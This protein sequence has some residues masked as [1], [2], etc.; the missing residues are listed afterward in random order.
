MK[1]TSFHIQGP[2]HIELKSFADDRG[3]FVERY[4]K[5]PFKEL[6]IPDLIQDNFSR[7]KPG[8]LRGLHYQWDQPQG[9]LVTATKGK[10]FDVAVDIRKDSPT[11]GQSISVILDGD[12]PSWFWIPAGFAH[13]FCVI[14]E[15]EADVMY[16]VNNYWN[17]KAESGIVWNDQ[18]FNI[19]W[20]IKNPLL[21][22]K[23]AVMQ[24][25]KNYLKDPKF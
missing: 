11:L 16:K 2:L 24:T 20:P 12:S 21:S 10:I 5:D 13:G 14:S 19:Q 23:D 25:F 9:K 8:V 4:K 6:G 18:D 22:A 7:S 1:I 3:F 17:P 15:T